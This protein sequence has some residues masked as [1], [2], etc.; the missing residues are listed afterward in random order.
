ML[1]TDETY[2]A[3]G[4]LRRRKLIN[5]FLLVGN[6][7]YVIYLSKK[8][9]CYRICPLSVSKNSGLGV[10]HQKQKKEVQVLEITPWD[11]PKSIRRKIIRAIRVK[12]AT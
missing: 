9:A 5:N 10:R 4:P 1:E 3:L 8:A 2:K 12:E 7:L 6:S 11:T